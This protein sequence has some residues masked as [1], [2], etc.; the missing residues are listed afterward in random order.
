MCFMHA[1]NKVITLLEFQM[2]FV[3]L[4]KHE[5]VGGWPFVVKGLKS[6]LPRQM[7]VAEG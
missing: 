4:C 5:K 1:T 2:Y 7:Q 3:L 6:G